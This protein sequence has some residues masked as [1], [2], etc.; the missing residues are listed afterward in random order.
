MTDNLED[1]VKQI[2]QV[3]RAAT[4]KERQDLTSSLRDLRKNSPLRVRPDVEKW[5]AKQPP[6]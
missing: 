2:S 4:R 1:L 3:K 5:L 6:R